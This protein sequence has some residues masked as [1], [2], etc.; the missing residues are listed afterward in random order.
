VLGE[1]L[2]YDEETFERA[3][4]YARTGLVD[5][6]LNEFGVLLCDFLTGAEQ[7][8]LVATRLGQHVQRRKRREDDVSGLFD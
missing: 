2:G 4:D 1:E 6:E 8:A 5:G 3:A 7:R